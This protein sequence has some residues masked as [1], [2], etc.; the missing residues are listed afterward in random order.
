MSPRHVGTLARVEI[1]RA[2]PLLGRLYLA[3]AAGLALFFAL[4]R[5]SG[6]NVLVVIMGVTMGAAAVMPFA[7]MR[8]KLDH[9]LEFLLSLPVTVSDL[10]TARFLAAALGLLPGAI[11]TGVAFA[12]VT[13]P[14]EFCVIAAASPFPIAARAAGGWTPTRSST[15]QCLIDAVIAAGTSQPRWAR[16]LRGRR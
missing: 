14:E 12:L 1:Q 7:V 10:V 2:K 16:R 8:D 6:E 3:G 5:G 4:G 9:T 11:A 15:R 13:P